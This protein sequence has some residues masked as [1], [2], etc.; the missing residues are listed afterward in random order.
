VQKQ[1]L[2]SIHALQGGCVWHELDFVKRQV[3][4]A[5]LGQKLHERDVSCAHPVVSQVQALELHAYFQG[6][7]NLRDLLLF[8][9]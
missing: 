7:E 6:L 8:K 2:K 5:Q 1:K 9:N 3:K 4:L